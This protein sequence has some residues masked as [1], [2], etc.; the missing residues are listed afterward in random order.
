MV[1][2]KGTKVVFERADKTKD[3]REIY[4]HN[5]DVFSES[6]DF[7]WTYDD[8]RREVE[9]GWELYSVKVQEEIIAALFCKVDQG[10]LLTKNTALKMNF[11][12]RGLSHKIKDFFEEMAAGRKV[13]SISHYC[14]VDDFRAYSLNE[15]HGYKRVDKTPSSKDRVVEWV[16]KPRRAD[17]NFTNK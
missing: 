9:E 10:R 6:P 5:L 1:T 17:K 14:R 7:E 15:G 4:G 8:I 13:S 3:F 12:G 11:Q 16:K 2:T